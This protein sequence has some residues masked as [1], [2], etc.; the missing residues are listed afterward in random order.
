MGIYDK[1]I[2]Y[3]EVVFVNGQKQANAFI[4]A[5]ALPSIIGANFAQYMRA[6][7]IPQKIIQHILRKNN[8]MQE[9]NYAL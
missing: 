9:A 3:I 7:N 1:D 4:K 6:R 5:E 2:D 8:L